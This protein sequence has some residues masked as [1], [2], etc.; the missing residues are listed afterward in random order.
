[1]STPLQKIKAHLKLAKSKF[2][3]LDDL[4]ETHPEYAIVFLLEMMNDWVDQQLPEEKK[5]IQQAM[6]HALDEDGHTGD[7]KAQ[8]IKAY[9]EKISQEDPVIQESVQ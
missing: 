1:M 8:F 2:R 3:D 7:W 9:Y 5:M 4:P 6:L